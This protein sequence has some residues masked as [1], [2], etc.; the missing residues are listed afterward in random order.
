MLTVFNGYTN[1]RQLLVLLDI[2]FAMQHT[3]QMLRIWKG[4]LQSLDRCPFLIRTCKYFHVCTYLSDVS[5]AKFWFRVGKE[6]QV[7]FLLPIPMQKHCANKQRGFM[8]D[9][10][11]HSVVLENSNS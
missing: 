2:A 3:K 8:R 6:L 9:F 7:S 1:I 10:V 11:D 5:A 4:H